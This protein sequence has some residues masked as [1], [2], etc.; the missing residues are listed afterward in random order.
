MLKVIQY[1]QVKI[2]N[3]ADWESGE[4]KACLKS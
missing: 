2:K 3:A 1:I 4:G